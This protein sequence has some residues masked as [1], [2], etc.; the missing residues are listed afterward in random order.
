M[1]A[2]PQGHFCWPECFTPD[3]PST[4]DFYT[5]LFGWAWREVPSAG[6]NYGIAYL[7]EE[8]VAAAFQ[9]PASL[10]PP[11][12]NSYVQ[13]ENADDV[14]ARAKALGGSVTAGPF[15]VPEV[16]R[17][18]FLADPG[19]AAIAL[20]QSG[21]NVGATRWGVPGTLIWTELTTPAAETSLRFYT[22]LFGWQARSRTDMARPYVEFHHGGRGVGGLLPASR[23]PAAWVPYFQAEDP[24]ASVAKAAE[25]RAR[26]IVPVTGLPGIGT[27]A[28]LKDPQGARFG[29]LRLEP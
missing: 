27:F 22:T 4:Q 3:L 7:G 19:G 28:L 15:E 29:L 13:V 21:R 11:R 16:G 1:P 5:G 9:A 26:V 2:A 18:A 24:D 23:G 20:W 17:M 8:A 10:G 25:A 6:A 12:W 14:A